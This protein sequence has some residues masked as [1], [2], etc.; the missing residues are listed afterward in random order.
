MAA[1]SCNAFVPSYRATHVGTC[2]HRYVSATPMSTRL[3]SEKGDIS[4]FEGRSST[5]VHEPNDFRTFLNQCSLQ[6]FMFLLATTR[7]LHTVRWLDRFTKPV[8]RFRPTGM[9]ESDAL[10]NLDFE[11]GSSYEYKEDQKVSSRLLQYH[12]LSALNTTLFPTWESYYLDLLEQEPIVLLIE[13]NNP[14]TPFKSFEIDIEPPRLC[15]RMLSVREQIA[16]EWVRDL[17]VIGS[18]GM[19]VFQSYWENLPTGSQ[20]D[21]NRRGGSTPTKA[22][23][24]QNLV[25]LELSPDPDS[26]YMPSP[27]RKGNFDLLILMSTEESVRRVC[28]KGIIVRSDDG[29][30]TIDTVST[31]YLKRFY[32]E[33]IMSH[34]RGPKKYGRADDFI[35]EL[36]LSPSM[37]TTDGDSVT[38]F[39]DPIKITEVVMQQREVVALEWKAIA[40]GSPTE[41]TEIRK[42]QLN[43][44]MGL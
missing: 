2:S 38:G 36:M 7:D 24:R 18:M 31:N 43:K 27:L 9:D 37:M 29:E 3:F 4:S 28:G 25:F 30:S 33:R 42:L 15:S 12:G 19:Q 22:F 6:S 44:M 13:S 5:G 11:D 35:E 40:E 20:K 8:L 39:I 14:A 23:E 1:A 21:E 16:R 41:H 26:D 10:F 32:E 34:F 17:D